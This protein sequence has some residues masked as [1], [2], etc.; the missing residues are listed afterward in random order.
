MGSPAEWYSKF[1]ANRCLPPVNRPDNV[2]NGTECY[3]LS[4]K[5]VEFKQLPTGDNY[6]LR[7]CFFDTKYKAFFGRRFASK[8]YIGNENAI[9]IDEV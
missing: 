2:S 7:V 6:R 4:L 1:L 8:Y 5:V 3:A 9:I